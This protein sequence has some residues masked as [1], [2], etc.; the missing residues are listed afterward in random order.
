[1]DANVIKVLEAAIMAPSGENAQPWKFVV[2]R[3]QDGVVID[4]LVSDER[5]QS[6]YGWG[7]RASYVAIGAAVENMR[8]AA[9]SYGFSISS[10]SSPRRTMRSS[11]PESLLHG[12][13]PR[14]IRLQRTSIR[15]PRIASPMTAKRFL[16]QRYAC[17]RQ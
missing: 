3:Q 6:L 15:A 17:S 12:V 5:A 13:S 7:N 2:H 8:V 1:M 4:V 14:T 16:T 11:P 9:P 10:L